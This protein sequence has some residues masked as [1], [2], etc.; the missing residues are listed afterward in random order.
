M[1]GMGNMQGMMKQMQKMQKDM[2]KAAEELGGKEFEAT[3]GGGAVVV[4]INGNK[5]ILGVNLKPEV[6]D[7]DDI[8]MLEDLILL[9]VNDA[10]GQVESA[11]NASMGQF[12]QGLPKGLF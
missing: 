10:L 7:P 11:S 12:T 4:K 9:A 5:E 1:R 8:E 2:A 6:V 3:A